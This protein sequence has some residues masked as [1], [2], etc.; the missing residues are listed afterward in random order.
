MMSDEAERRVEVVQ[1]I[2]QLQAGVQHCI[3]KIDANTE[4]TEK[5]LKVLYENGLVTQVALNKQS[6]GRLWKWTGIV[7]T[8]IL[9][10]AAWIFRGEV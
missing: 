5:L 4:L 10:L 7:S 1:A 3:E 8:F 6:L 2:T 9:G